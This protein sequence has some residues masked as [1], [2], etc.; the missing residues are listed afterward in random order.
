[1]TVLAIVLLIAVAVS[2]TCV[3]L[4]SLQL[5]KALQRAENLAERAISMVENVHR[6]DQVQLSSVLD[7]FM[8]LDLDHFKTYQL[9]ESADEVEQDGMTSEDYRRERPWLQPEE[10]P[11]AFKADHERHYGGE[12]SD[13]LERLEEEGL[14][15]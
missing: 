9:A 15:R 7:R 10:G 11:S 2:V 3:F 4:T 14:P 1:M 13:T 6:A 8:A 5:S 12:E